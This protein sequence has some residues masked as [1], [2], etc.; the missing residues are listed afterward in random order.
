[1]EMAGIAVIERNVNSRFY[2]ND[3]ALDQS[4]GV[5]IASPCSKVV[6]RKG[7]P[8]T[9]V[10]CW[11]IMEVTSQ[12]MAQEMGILSSQPL[13]LNISWRD[14]EQDLPASAQHLLYST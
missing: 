12:V 11:A 8:S 4:V 3:I 14:R 6:G 2:R 5:S 9:T 13:Q 7:L 1:M 10:R